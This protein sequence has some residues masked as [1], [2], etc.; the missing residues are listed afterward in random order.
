MK[1][2][3]HTENVKADPYGCPYEGYY[4]GA[5]DPCGDLYLMSGPYYSHEDA[6]TRYWSTHNQVCNAEPSAQV[7]DWGVT[8]WYGVDDERVAS[9]T[10]QRRKEEGVQKAIEQIREKVRW[11]VLESNGVTVVH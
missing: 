3:H 2:R 8:E 4:V 6:A 10:E 5:I 11:F 9:I 7:W 1:V